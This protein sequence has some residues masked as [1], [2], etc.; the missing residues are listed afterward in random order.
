MK[1]LMRL[2]K[3]LVES[4]AMHFGDFRCNSHWS[5][6]LCTEQSSKDFQLGFL[7][8]KEVK[9]QLLAK[10]NMLELYNDKYSIQCLS[11]CTIY[12][13]AILCGLTK[14]YGPPGTD[15]EALTGAAVIIVK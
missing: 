2:S 9:A 4:I 6:W 10:T 14:G 11:L 12:Y 1:M 3:Y 7:Y 8:H 5:V 13:L 15:M